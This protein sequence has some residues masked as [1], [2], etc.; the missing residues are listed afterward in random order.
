MWDGHSQTRRSLQA[1][2]PVSG[3]LAEKSCIPDQIQIDLSTVLPKVLHHPLRLS[4]IVL[5]GGET[6]N[7]W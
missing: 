4:R 3:C 6:G 2:S 7:A 1:F 5:G